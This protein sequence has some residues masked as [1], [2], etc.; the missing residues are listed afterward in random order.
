MNAVPAVSLMGVP[1]IPVPELK[2]W[3]GKVTSK[4]VAEAPPLAETVK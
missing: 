2:V 3:L 4:R 1:E